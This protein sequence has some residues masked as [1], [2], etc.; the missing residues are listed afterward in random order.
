[1][2]V[3]GWRTTALDARTG[4]IDGI[5]LP[6]FESVLGEGHFMIKF[7][8]VQILRSS[9]KL[10]NS[11]SFGNGA[12]LLTFKDFPRCLIIPFTKAFL[13]PE[14]TQSREKVNDLWEIPERQK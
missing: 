9:F 3:L 4:A 1:M 8:A 7:K 6:V 14:E 11:E 2:C 5:V 12:H 10:T 13:L